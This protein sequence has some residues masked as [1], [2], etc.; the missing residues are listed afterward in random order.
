ML[1]FEQI[2]A[3]SNLVCLEI[4]QQ[5]TKSFVNS[6]REKEK[7]LTYNNFGENNAPL[8]PSFLQK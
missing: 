2:C 7:L 8:V 4:L 3:K 1:K 5:Y 6:I